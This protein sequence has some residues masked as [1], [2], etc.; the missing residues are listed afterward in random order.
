MRMN[1]K[2][3]N[4][5]TQIL[6]LK[7]IHTSVHMNMFSF[8]NSNLINFHPFYY[9]FCNKNHTHMKFIIAKSNMS[10]LYTW[11]SIKQTSLS[12]CLLDQLKVCWFNAMKLFQSN[13]KITF[14]NRWHSQFFK[15]KKHAIL[16]L[17]MHPHNGCR[18]QQKWK[19]PICIAIGLFV[20]MWCDAFDNHYLKYS[21]AAL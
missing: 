18:I 20:V 5:L 16:I 12:V 17:S 14:E 6:K 9:R 3:K 11:F 19:P 2:Q 7:Y 4:R 13:E 15:Q 21:D 10:L 8:L 1:E